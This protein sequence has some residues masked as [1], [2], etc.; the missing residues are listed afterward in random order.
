MEH[1]SLDFKM[2][3][4]IIFNFQAHSKIL[5]WYVIHHPSKSPESVNY[6]NYF[7]ILASA[8]SVRFTR[9]FNSTSR[10]SVN[11][12]LATSLYVFDIVKAKFLL[13][14]EFI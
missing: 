12:W 13:S 2:F 1:L 8:I 10:Q 6:P 7:T 9:A 5:I 14:F 4:I 3:C 11:S